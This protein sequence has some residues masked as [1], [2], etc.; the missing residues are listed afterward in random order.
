MIK[1]FLLTLLLFSFLGCASQRPFIPIISGD[2]ADSALE[3]KN[4]LNKQGF[5]TQ[6]M[7]GITN[8]QGHVWIEYKDK[9]TGEWIRVNNLKGA[10]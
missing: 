9:K 5:E 6:L 2:C 7:I 1:Y 10:Q 8:I 4:L 3:L